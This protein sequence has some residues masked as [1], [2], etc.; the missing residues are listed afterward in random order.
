MR[1]LLAVVIVFAYAVMLAPRPWD[2]P[3]SEYRDFPTVAETADLTLPDWQAILR[4]GCR[5]V[6]SQGEGI[7]FRCPRGMAGRW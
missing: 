5:R 3:W 2:V 4:D 6:P 7:S 1:V